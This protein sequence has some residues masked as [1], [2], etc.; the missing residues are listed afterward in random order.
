[1]P[2]SFFNIN[3]TTKPAQI[4]PDDN[5]LVLVVDGHVA[6]HVVREGVDVWRVLVL[7]L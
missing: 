3:L 2:T 5:A 6:V 4:L 1:M 7:S